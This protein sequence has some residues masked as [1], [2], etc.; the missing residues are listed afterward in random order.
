VLGLLGDP[1][2]ETGT[3]SFTFDGPAGDYRIALGT[4][5]EPDGV[6]TFVL[7]T[8]YMGRGGLVGVASTYQDLSDNIFAVAE[9]RV[10]LELASKIPV[11][12]GQSFKLIGIESEG[13]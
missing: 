11:A 5:D 13:T 4:F 9:N 2:G 1:T 10:E 12:T 7:A 3:A 8:S 6:S